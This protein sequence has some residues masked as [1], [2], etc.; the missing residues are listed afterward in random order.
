MKDD[1]FRNEL[2]YQLLDSFV[3]QTSIV[4]AG[5]V[6]VAAINI[7]LFWL[8]V[9]RVFIGVWAIGLLLVAVFRWLLKA[10]YQR[11]QR[12]SAPRF[13]RRLFAASS[14][15][16][17]LVWLVWCLYVTMAMNFGGTGISIIVITAAGLVS[18]AVASTSSSIVSYVCFSGP[19]LLPLGVVLLFNEQTETRGIGVL[20]IV[21]FVVILRQVQRIN[22]VLRDSIINSLEL[23][24]SKEQTEKLANELY[25]LSTR[26]ALTSVTNRRGFD[27]ALSHEWMRARRSNT[28]LTLLMID[29][30]F[31]KTFNDSLGH[32]A[33]DDCLRRIASTLTRYARRA[34]EV[35]ARYGG[36][37]F[38]VLLPNTDA[39][40]G[41]VIAENI[42]L[43]I[44][45]LG[46][47]HPASGV[48]DT[49]TV[50]V[51]VCGVEPGQLEDGQALL[52]LADHA[53]YQAKAAGRN[54]VRSAGPPV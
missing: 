21:F 54:C 12:R 33:G 35:I 16:L 31:F 28:P 23:E 5:H 48:G 10:R 34:G 15:S 39:R 49:V 30:D 17:G 19:I 29:V 11:Y 42:R 27:E 2:D 41:A 20:L 8:T 1:G 22:L 25:E 7:A 45:E 3:K 46:I 50:S 18:G 36:E 37:E 6:L 13:W 38:A 51:G 40:E 43:G 26:D 44:A 4:V 14:L 9:S 32:P 24:K 52:R 47:N 53:L